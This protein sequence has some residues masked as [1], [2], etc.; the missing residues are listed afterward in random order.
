[1]QLSSSV[2]YS[3]PT[4]R[5]SFDPPVTRLQLHKLPAVRCSPIPIIIYSERQAFNKFMIRIIGYV[6]EL[7]TLVIFALLH[8]ISSKVN[9]DKRSLYGQLQRVATKELASIAAIKV[10][11]IASAVIEHACLCRYRASIPNCPWSS[12]SPHS[13]YT[14]YFTNYFCMQWATAHLEGLWCTIGIMRH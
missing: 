6:I 5:F 10:V 14:I 4:I 7:S 11:S 2:L 8:S 12:G 3:R 1:M 13:I 9:S